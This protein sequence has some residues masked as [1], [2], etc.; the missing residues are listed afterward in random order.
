DHASPLSREILTLQV[1]LA[2]ADGDLVAVQRWITGLDRS[3]G[4][5]E[6]LAP[7]AAE[8]ETLMLARWHLAQGRRE[9]ALQLLQDLLREAQEAGRRHSAFETRALQALVYEAEE[10]QGRARQILLT[11]LEQTCMEGYVRLFLDEGE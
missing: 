9:A 8:Q 6:L 4:L 10:Q 5:D 7:F 11:L 2:L 1:R 3:G